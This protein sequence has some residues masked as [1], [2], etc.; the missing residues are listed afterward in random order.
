MIVAVTPN[1][2]VDRAL[3]IDALHRG[4][5]VRSRSR[6]VEPGGKGINVVRALVAHGVDAEAVVPVGGVEGRQ[7][8][9]LLE[10][11]GIRPRTVRISGPSRA[12]VSLVEPDGTVTKINEP[13]P[14][15]TT[16][17]VAELLAVTADLAGGADWVVSC[18]S[19]PSGAPD[20]L[21]AEVVR[22]ARAAGSRT[23]V[24]TSGDP[25]LAAVAAGPDLVKPNH[26]ELAQAVGGPITTL[27]DTVAAARQL[28]AR[29]ARAVLA[30]LGPDGAVLVGPD[31]VWH[32]TC[33][34]DRPVSSVG[35]GDATLAGYLTAADR[36]PDEALRMAVAFGAAAVQLPGTSMPGPLDLHP[37]LVRVTDLLDLARPLASV[38]RGED[39]ARLG[40][41]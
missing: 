11:Q 14:V 31:G 5:V 26:D 32:A 41:R 2:S 17:E 20:D 38:R 24:D 34:V 13:G 8:V 28:Q 35:A 15:M 27:G 16:V 23:A 7:L 39:P 33:P 18:G 25:L 19:L 29:G 10:H 36:A 37:E 21:H 6:R 30:S 12:N 22:R 40:V 1:P 4:D 3:E 9:E